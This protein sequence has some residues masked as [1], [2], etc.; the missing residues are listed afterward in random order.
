MGGIVSSNDG[1]PLVGGSDL[2][3]GRHLL[4]RFEVEERIARGGSSTVYRGEDLKL[5]RPVCIKVFDYAEPDPEIREFVLGSFLRE[6]QALSMLSHPHTL[7]IY[8]FGYLADETP[9]QITEFL[10]GGTLAQR[11]ATCGPMS[12]NDAT[13]LVRGL[14][15]AL[16]EAH[17][18]GLVH[19]DVKPS[20]VLFADN[21]PSLA[22][23]G[24]FGIASLLAP[25]LPNQPR[26]SSAPLGAY[27]LNWSAPEQFVGGSVDPSSDVYA[28]ALVAIHALTGTVAMA[29]RTARDALAAR[30][31]P[32]TAIERACADDVVPKAV[33]DLVA[34][35]C[36]YARDDR[37][38]SALDFAA[39][40]AAALGVAESIQPLRLQADTTDQL[41]AGRI[42]KLVADS[43]D[44]RCP[45][46][47]LV[48][49]A[50]LRCGQRT[51]LQLRG[52]D[53]YLSLEDGPPTS[54]VQIHGTS[55]V[56]IIRPGH[57]V[58][59]R[60]EGSVAE[61][62]GDQTVVTIGHRPHVVDDSTGPRPLAA[63]D[64]GR[65]RECFVLSAYH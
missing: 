5:S 19:C 50:T 21:P 32:R 49:A 17:G 35:T 13:V 25:G 11:I 26:R 44:V 14:A 16:A 34:R 10:A 38:K 33:I 12:A 58:T 7:R 42:L 8:E 65:G 60:I 9:F 23:L 39:R 36:C 30:I 57:G 2:Q 37:P 31:D 47:G 52:V 53:C 18:L 41:V 40:L 56:S 1:V 55:S 63:V 43:V 24:D 15:G 29:A 64:L 45:G 4:D 59:G 6:A 48:R 22:K 62:H 54:A 51:W 27:S 3:P 46:G 28:L 61:R 20:N